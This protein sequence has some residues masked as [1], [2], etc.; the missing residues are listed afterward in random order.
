MLKNKVIIFNIVTI[1]VFVLTFWAFS[2]EK[3]K[4]QGSVNGT[5]V[6]QTQEQ[7]TDQII[8][9]YGEGCPHCAIVEK[10]LTENKI[11]DRV[12]FAQKEIYHNIKNREELK[13]KAEA[14]GLSLD[15]IGVPFLWDGEK[16]LIG[17]KDIITFFQ[18]KE[19]E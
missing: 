14:C 19:G 11:K 12:T 5:V 1:I 15:A 17:D 4:I 16:C 10:Y 7:E 6:E 13:F 9:F 18:Q 3:D 2:Q 8:L